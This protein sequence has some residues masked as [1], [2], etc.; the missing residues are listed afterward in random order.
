MKRVLLTGMSGTGKSTLIK[1]LAARGYKAVDADD[2]GLSEWVAVP[3]DEPT[4]LGRGQDWVWREDRIQ[5]LLASD[6][7][8][9]LFLSGCSPNQGTFYPQF[10]HIVLLTAPAAV[11][12]ERLAP[13]PPTATAS[14]PMR[15]PGSLPCSKRSSRCCEL[16][17]GWRWTPA[18]PSTRSWPPS[19][20]WCSHPTLAHP[21]DQ[22]LPVCLNAR[23]DLGVVPND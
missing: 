14:T 13:G 11:I 23:A 16:A 12:V 5:D 18:P 20:G 21:S 2:H 3:L 4:G 8:E 1:A 17:P 6:D 15:S 7:A 9:V 10:D 22:V 19:C